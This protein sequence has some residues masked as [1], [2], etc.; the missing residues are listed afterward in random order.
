LKYFVAHRGEIITRE[1]L[2]NE[3]W[4]YDNFPLTRTVDNH[5]ARLRQKIEA[6]PND[7]QFIITVHRLGYKF[8][9]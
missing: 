5:I 2:L 8:L 7:P 1:Q 3:V 6:A 9:G 4:G